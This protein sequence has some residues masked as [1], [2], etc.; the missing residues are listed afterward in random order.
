[1]RHIPDLDGIVQAS[2]G[3]VHVHRPVPV[4]VL[5]LGSMSRELNIALADVLGKSFSRQHPK[6]DKS[7]F[8]TSGKQILVVRTELEIL[9]LA[10]VSIDLVR[11]RINLLEIIRF[12][13]NNG[14]SRADLLGPSSEDAIRSNSK[15]VYYSICVSDAG[16]FLLK[17]VYSDEGSVLQT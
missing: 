3:N 2:G 8:R 1:M 6:L 11:V 13:D 5:N 15:S 14:S 9:N 10:L 4:K 7:I 16:K 17:E 12:H